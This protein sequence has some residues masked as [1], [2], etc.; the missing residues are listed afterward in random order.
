[1]KE[2]WKM[3]CHSLLSAFF[4]VIFWP[5]CH[6]RKYGGHSKLTW[7]NVKTNGNDGFVWYFFL[8]LNFFLYL[9]KFYYCTHKK[10]TIHYKASH[11][12]SMSESSISKQIAHSCNKK[13]YIRNTKPDND[14]IRHFQYFFKKLTFC[15]IP[16]SW[17]WSHLSR[18]SPIQC[19]KVVKG[20][21]TGNN[22]CLE[23]TLSWGLPS[24]SHHFQIAAFCQRFW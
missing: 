19:S 20:A 23:I 15:E 9:Y 3:I 16:W 8:K 21:L 11:L 12:A 22:S 7:N 6:S 14:K 24:K 2:I 18:K 5:L 4:C 1:M 10:T 17:F 13:Q